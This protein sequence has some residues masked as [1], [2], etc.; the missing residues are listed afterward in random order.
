MDL[1]TPSHQAYWIFFFALPSVSDK[2]HILTV[3]S[4]HIRTRL[5]AFQQLAYMFVMMSEILSNT[6]LLQ[7]G[8]KHEKLQNNN[9][10]NLGFTTRNCGIVLTNNKYLTYNRTG[11]TTI[12]FTLLIIYQQQ[13]EIFS[14]YI[15]EIWRIQMFI[16]HWIHFTLS[17]KCFISDITELWTLI[18]M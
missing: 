15:Q 18:T 16:N 14:T 6:V 3:P 2:L 9:S 1:Q 5:N 7:M 12:Y 17:N 8:F 4:M 13:T 11:K 10:E